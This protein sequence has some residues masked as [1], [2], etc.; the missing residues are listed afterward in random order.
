MRVRR[1]TVLIEVVFVAVIVGVVAM[2]A[3]CGGAI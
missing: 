3:R 2:M 1:A